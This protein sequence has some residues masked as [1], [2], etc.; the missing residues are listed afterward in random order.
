MRTTAT[1]LGY[2]NRHVWLRIPPEVFG[3]SITLTMPRSWLTHGHAKALAF[4]VEV[5]PNS[6]VM[7]EELSGFQ[8][9]VKVIKVLEW[10]EDVCRART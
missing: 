3:R 4:E 5:N 7:K 8:A 2:N 10:N 6:L 1:M 9:D